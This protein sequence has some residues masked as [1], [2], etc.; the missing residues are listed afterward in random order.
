MISIRNVYKLLQG[1]VKERKAKKAIG[2]AKYVT[3][4]KM[5]REEEEGKQEL[6]FAEAIRPLGELKMTLTCQ[7]ISSYQTTD[8][9]LCTSDF[10]LELDTDIFKI[11]LNRIFE[12]SNFETSTQYCLCLMN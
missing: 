8:W 1:Q 4:K 9:K 7:K 10:P 6:E 2:K 11:I 5:C 12:N 3:L